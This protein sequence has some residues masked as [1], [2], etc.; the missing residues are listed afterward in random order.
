MARRECPLGVQETYECPN[1]WGHG[2]ILSS[3]SDAE[4]PCENCGGSGEVDDC[5]FCEFRASQLD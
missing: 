5:P 3:C 1:C 4:Y 2:V